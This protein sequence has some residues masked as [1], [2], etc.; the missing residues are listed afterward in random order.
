MA[1]EKKDEAV[2]GEDLQKSLDQL[3]EIT[4]RDDPAARKDALLAKAKEGDLEKAEKTELFELLGGAPAAT[5]PEPETTVGEDLVKSMTDEGNTGLQEA[6]D[7]SPY[8]REQHEALTKS[9]KDV[10][11]HIEKS[12]KRQYELSCMQSRALVDIGNLVKSMSERLGVIEQQPVRGPKSKGVT[13]DQT[14]TKSF[15]GDGGNE[16]QL[17]KSDISTALDGLMAE[18]MDGGQ[19][20]L[21]KGGHDILLEI[22]KFEQSSKLSPDMFREVKSFIGRQGAA[23]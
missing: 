8:L 12:D 13:P 1:E 9:L 4:T 6:L 15:D 10:G 22:S 16:E 19:N 3:E 20:G 7:V 18:S 23:H 2:T 11:D 21:S 14:L 5:D 17:S